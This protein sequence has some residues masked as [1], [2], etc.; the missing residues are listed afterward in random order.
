MLTFDGSTTVLY[1][2]HGTGELVYVMNP[3]CPH[4]GCTVGRY[5]TTTSK[6]SC[7][8]HGSAFGID[9]SL[10]NGPATTGLQRYAS[11]ITQGV[12]EVEVPNFEFGIRQVSPILTTAGAPRLALSFPT[13]SRAA[14]RLRR[15]ADT[16]GPFP[17]ASFALDKDGLLNQ[18]QMLGNGSVRT[19]YVD[20]ASPR[21]FFKL[22]LMISVLP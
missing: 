13:K 19:V 14:Y 12:L 16:S 2:I 20:A 11:R 4:A 21:S 22:E 5:N 6:T 3:T 9:G 15:A 18:T 7:P 17:A 10:L 8:C 1:I